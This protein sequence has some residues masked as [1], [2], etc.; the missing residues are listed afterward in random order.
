VLVHQHGLDNQGLPLPASDGERR[1][2][3]KAS[4]NAKAILIALIP[5]ACLRPA[6]ASGDPTLLSNAA[7]Q[8]TYKCTLTGYTLPASAKDPFIQ[9]S[10]G[11]FQISA[12]GA[13]HWSDATWNDR[14]DSSEVHANCKFKLGSGT[15]AV[16]PNGTGTIA[17][18]W[19][20]VTDGSSDN[21][22][23]FSAGPRD[24]PGSDQ[25]IITDGTGARF[26]SAALNPACRV[27]EHLREAKANRGRV[28]RRP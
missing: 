22:A 21:C 4:I 1:P 5:V 20:L 28:R 7:I 8:G 17:M 3:K 23:Q 13:G 26:Y 15:Y 14:I 25:L 12:H 6:Y 10:S 9:T 18:K 2:L 11:D 19:K 27:G 16:N 24:L